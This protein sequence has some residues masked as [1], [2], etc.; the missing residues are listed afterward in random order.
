MLTSTRTLTLANGEQFPYDRLVLATGS[1]PFVPPI[2][3]H[4]RE[5]CGSGWLGI[6]R[7]GE[8]S[9]ETSSVSTLFRRLKT[10]SSAP[11]RRS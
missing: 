8:P 9:C 1:V 2:P 6:S 10:R 4:Q 11:P 3:G 7:P 5:G